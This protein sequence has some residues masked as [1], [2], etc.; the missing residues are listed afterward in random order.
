M[1]PDFVSLN[2]LQPIQ[3]WPSWSLG[4]EVID[5]WFG[6]VLVLA[7]ATFGPIFFTFLPVSQIRYM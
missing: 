7:T 3:F 5:Q 4:P 2:T 6:L 1:V